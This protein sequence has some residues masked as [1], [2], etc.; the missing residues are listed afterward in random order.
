MIMSSRCAKEG[1]KKKLKITDVECRC[2]VRFCVNHRHPEEHSCTSLE[3]ERRYH[4]QELAKTLQSASFE[5][6]QT[7]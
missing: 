2:G 5:K 4:K 6:V 1:C 3:Q 7:I